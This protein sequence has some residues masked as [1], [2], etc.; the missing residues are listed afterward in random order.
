MNTRLI[1]HTRRLQAR[2]LEAQKRGFSL[3][4]LMVVIVIIG[5][6]ATLVAP[7]ALD[8]LRR[9]MGSKAEID[10]LALSAALDEYA[11]NNAGRYPETLEELVLPDEHGHSY[12]QQMRIPRDPWD[13]EYQY[14][15]PGGNQTRPRVYTLGKDGTVG[16]EGDDRDIDNI[17]LLGGEEQ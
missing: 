9:A 1:R 16:G 5:L 8:A 10:I 15:P 6:L 4:E 12:L 7:R 14:E 13:M 2:K 17:R 11:I 3:A